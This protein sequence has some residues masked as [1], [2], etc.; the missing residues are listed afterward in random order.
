ML[1][2]ASLPPAAG[3]LRAVQWLR[4]GRRRRSGDQVGVRSA[5]VSEID[6]RLIVRTV[7]RSDGLGIERPELITTDGFPDLAASAVGELAIEALEQTREIPRPMSWPRRS[8]YA[9]PLLAASPGRYRSFRSWQRA[10]RQVNV[11]ASATEITLIR[12]HPDLSRGSWGPA[13]SVARPVDDWPQHVTLPPD[14]SAAD[15][16]QALLAVLQQPSLRDA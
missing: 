5:V 4:G 15:I 3:M 13:E 9:Q 7:D 1:L 8:E 10:A 2:V 16:G 12:E 6:G 11:S 14:A